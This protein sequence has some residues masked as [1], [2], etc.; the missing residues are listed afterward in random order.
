MSPK[1]IKGV[2]ALLCLTVLALLT[3]GFVM[4][5][6]TSSSTAYHGD[7]FYYAKRQAMWLGL[8]LVA[9]AGTACLDYHRYRNCAWQMF[10]TAA[11]LLFLVLIFGRRINGALR[12]LVFG[13]FRLQPS[14]FAKYVLVVVLAFWLEKMQRAPKG[15]LQP[16]IQHWWYGVFAPLA[17]AGALGVL[18][19]KEPDMG[20]TMLLG[21]VA[22]LLMWVAG[23]SSRWLA[24]IVGAGAVGATACLIAIFRFGMFQRS[25][26]VQRIIHW[27]RG[28][29]LQGSN[30]QQYVAT[31][32]FGSGGTSGLGLGNSRMKMTYLPEAHTDFILPI[33]GEE[34][35]LVATLAVVIAFCVLVT[36]GILLAR[37]SPDLFG[38]LLGSGI[39][40][41]VGLQAIINIAVVTNSIP[42]KGMPLPFISYGGSNLVMTLAAFGILL[43]IVRQAH[44]H[45]LGTFLETSGGLAS[46]VG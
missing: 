20:A 9:C 23:S 11:V 19:F 18:V 25:Y 30:Y 8:G 15:Q 44:A 27:W 14:E 45:A 6:S 4:L 38:M 21:A 1:A 24:A 43:N 46:E 33:I 7:S 39:T 29:D 36:C 42:N 34:L 26:Q 2:T 22:L 28:D 41:I 37:R 13:P 31:L 10:I 5:A 12:W 40:A 16:R 32:A 35:G 3:F 17:I